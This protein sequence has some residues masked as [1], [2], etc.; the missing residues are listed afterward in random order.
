MAS[1]WVVVVGPVGGRD[2]RGWADLMASWWVV[3]VGPGQLAGG[4]VRG[5]ALM[6]SWWVV[7]VG[8]GQWRAGR[9]WVGRS[10]GQLAALPCHGL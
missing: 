8:P 6:A 4:M 5:A 1:W 9:S 2:G 3:V 10:D 7:V